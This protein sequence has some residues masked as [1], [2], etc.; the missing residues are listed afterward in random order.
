MNAA[1][2][3]RG[4]LPGTNGHANGH[5][6]QRSI[7]RSLGLI[8]RPFLLVPDYELPTGSKSRHHS[9]LNVNGTLG[10]DQA[11]PSP[12]LQTPLDAQG[13]LSGQGIRVGQPNIQGN[14]SRSDLKEKKHGLWCIVK[15]K[16]SIPRTGHL[17]L[18]WSLSTHTQKNFTLENIG[19]DPSGNTPIP[20]GDWICSMVDDIR[21]L[22]PP[23]SN[24]GIRT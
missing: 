3:S 15:R 14:A 17:L 18:M 5:T 2:A 19:S 12:Q 13:P 20:T 11:S 6:R 22:Q 24:A 7:H 9:Q 4:D 23:S 10:E 21:L 8:L 1:D 16:Y